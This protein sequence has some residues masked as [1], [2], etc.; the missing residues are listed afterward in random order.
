MKTNHKLV[1]AMLAGVSI[2][3]AGA[4]VIYAQQAKA[5]PAYVIAE[6]LGKSL[7]CF[8]TSHAGG[9]HI[10]SLDL[11]SRS[12]LSRRSNV[13]NATHFSSSACAHDRFSMSL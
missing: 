13:K 7:R 4:K 3:I 12:K 5:P 2:G 1:L 8:L 6:V 11:T 10:K 9:L